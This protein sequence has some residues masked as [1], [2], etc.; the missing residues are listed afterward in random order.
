MRKK[1]R[2]TRSQR[3]LGEASR[4]TAA[5]HAEFYS[6][7]PVEKPLHE[8]GH[9]SG[10]EQGQRTSRHRAR[11]ARREEK[12][13]PREKMALAAI[14][15][16]MIL[17]LMLG[18]AFFLL[19]KGIGL[20]EESIWLEHAKE[21]ESSPVLQDVVLVAKFDIQDQDARE[22]FAGRVELWRK[23]DRLVNSA[24]A[25][26]QR[27]IYDLAIERCQDALRLDPSHMGALDRLGQ[28]Y[29]KKENYVE[30]VNAYIRLL[31]VDPSRSEVQKKLIR[32]L[33]AYGDT[34][35]VMYMA[36]W[37]QE[38]NLYD[39][40]ITL[41]LA[42]ARY[43]R[44]EFPEAVE[45]YGRI[46][47]DTPLNILALER[48]ASAY[49]QIEQYDK[50]LI[51]LETLRGNNYREKE[52]YLKIAICNAQLKQSKESLLAL[53]R[54]AQLFDNRLVVG[55]VQDSRF[56]PIRSDRAFQS[57]ID[58]VAGAQTR[59][60]LEKQVSEELKKP[61]K[62][63]VLGIPTVDKLDNELLKPRK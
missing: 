60:W 28:L 29:F 38:Q 56:D 7:S 8:D 20:Y 21:R 54:A 48:Q 41:F 34:A 1:R 53:G 30:A 39:P 18:I 47:R 50:A 5:P 3:S 9:G 22:K 43:S 11:T 40:D 59:L 10:S 63:P 31:S 2:K 45:A 36:E 33:D 13:D 35:A 49:M 16:S 57:F 26:L 61:E 15:K 37:Y 62:V 52:Y 17:I 24:E 4:Q 25:L 32:A 51:P 14:L 44:E 27:N 42:N 6:A 55:W 58:R 23:A 19:W 46:L 12:I